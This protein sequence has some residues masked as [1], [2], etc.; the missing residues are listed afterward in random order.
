MPKMRGRAVPFD[1]DA[2]GQRAELRD[3]LLPGAQRSSLRQKQQK[4]ADGRTIGSLC[5]LGVAGP[6]TVLHA[7]GLPRRRPHRRVLDI[8]ASR[9]LV[10]PRGKAR[11]EER[12]ID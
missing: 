1:H 9:W 11:R 6:D 3:T 4:P 5:G 12:L 2:G 7:K 10:T 8:E